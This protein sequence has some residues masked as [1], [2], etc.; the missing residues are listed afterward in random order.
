MISKNR[1]CQA[2]GKVQNGAF[3]ADYC[4]GDMKCAVLL[5]INL[6][7]KKIAA[8]QNLLWMKAKKAG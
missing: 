1:V 5:K 6:H 7:R 4:K 2:E 3:L 8:M